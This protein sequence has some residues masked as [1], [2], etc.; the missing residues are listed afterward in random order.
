MRLPLSCGLYR[1]FPG[2]LVVIECGT[3]FFFRQSCQ[4]IGGRKVY[5]VLFQFL[6][7]LRGQVANDGVISSD[8]RRACVKH[9]CD[10]IAGP[11][12]LNPAVSEH[13]CD[14]PLQDGHE[15][16]AGL[17]LFQH[18]PQVAHFLDLV[19]RR[20][21]P[22]GVGDNQVQAVPD[23][24]IFRRLFVWLH[25]T[26][27]EFI[28]RLSIFHKGQRREAAAVSCNDFVFPVFERDDG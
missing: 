9:F 27:D 8:L 18:V 10:K 20:F 6:F 3:L 15:P 22:L 26:G 1:D 24:L 2:S 5:A 25:R 23:F 11:V 28:L 12:C 4:F 17:C 13:G 19:P 7:E 14:N 21:L 16:R